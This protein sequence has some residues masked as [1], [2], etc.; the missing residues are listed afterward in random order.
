MAELAGSSWN[1]ERGHAPLVATSAEYERITRGVSIH[2]TPRS[3]REFGM[4]SVEDLARDHDLM[5]IDHPHIGLIAQSGCAVALDEVIDPDG[6]ASLAAGSPGRSHESYH[7]A[8]HQWALAIDAACQVSAWR[9]DLLPAPPMTWAEVAALSRSGRVLW[10]LCG[11]DAAASMLTLLA[12]LKAPISFTAGD[13][14]DRIAARRGLAI[15]REIALAS[16]PRC[17]TANPIDALEA[18]SGGSTFCYTPLTF[19]YLNYARARHSGVEIRFCDIPRFAVGQPGRSI[20][21]GAGLAV[22]ASSQHRD[23]AIRY[24]LYAASAATQRSTY[25][26]AGGQPAHGEVWSD[27]AA[28]ELSGGFFAGTGPTMEASWTRPRDPGFVQFQNEM[29]ELFGDSRRWLTYPEEFLDDLEACYH[30]HAASRAS[31]SENIRSS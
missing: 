9:P 16:H 8:G 17:L 25:F 10:P 23:A 7:Y 6:L 30:R 1:H 22:S 19:G 12:S 24:A 27:L 4:S 3:L 2:W 18:L 5:V 11:V 28:D 15:L 21:G 29:I 20:L 14:L 13:V 31:A 26:A